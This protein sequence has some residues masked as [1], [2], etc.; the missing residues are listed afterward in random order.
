MELAGDGPGLPPEEV[1]A[2]ERLVRLELVPGERAQALGEAAHELETQLGLD[3]VEAAQRQRDLR[4]VGVAGALAHAVDRALDPVRA[5]SYRRDGGGCGETEVVVAVEVDRTVGA[6]P[7]A[8][9]ADEI[10]DCFRRRDPDRVDDHHLVRACLDGRL[11]D[12]LEVRGIRTCA[13]DAEERDGD[14]LLDRERDRVHDALEHRLA[15]DAECLELEVGDRRLDHAGADAELDERL[16]VRVD[17][18]GEAPD[19]G[20]EAGVA[21]QLDRAPI[22]RRHAWEAGLDPLDAELVQTAREL[23][24][25]TAR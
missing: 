24:T 5:G 13:V 17:G 18:A 10:R 4:E 2:D 20:L 16:H 6:E 25:R 1:L 19:L 22:V 9:P 14:A 12:R 23:R 7:F 3:A 15:V 11:V 21:D 8:R